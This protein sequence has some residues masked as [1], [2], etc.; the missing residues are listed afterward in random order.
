MLA[1]RSSDKKAQCLRWVAREEED[2]TTSGQFTDWLLQF[3]YYSSKVSQW[4]GVGHLAIA[5]KGFTQDDFE[6]I[7][8]DLSTSSSLSSVP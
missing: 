6:T 2:G 1:A 5:E 7:Y 4:A 3:T 8:I